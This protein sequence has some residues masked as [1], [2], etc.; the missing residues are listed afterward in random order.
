MIPKLAPISNSFVRDLQ[1][2]APKLAVPAHNLGEAAFQTACAGK[3]NIATL[4]LVLGMRLAPPTSLAAAARKAV[5]CAAGR[6][7]RHR[8]RMI[9]SEI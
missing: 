9:A 4:C 2:P 3:S 1:S 8:G 5:N 6:G 7:P